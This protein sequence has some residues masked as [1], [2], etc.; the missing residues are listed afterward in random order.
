M[1][2][3]QAEFPVFLAIV[4]LVYW[5]IQERRAQNLWLLGASVVFYGWVHP[6]FVALLFAASLV[7]FGT[8]QLMARVPAYK[9]ALLALSVASNLSLLAYF[10]YADFGL[11]NVIA[12]LD[13]L[14]LAHDVRLL[15]VMLPIGISFYTFQTIGYCVDVYRGE[16]RARRDLLDYLTYVSF[17]PQ[18]VA[19]P[20]ER[21]GRLL[22]QVERARVF[23]WTAMSTGVSLIAWG[24]FKKVVIADSVA[25]FVDKVFVLRDPAAPLV[26]AATAAFMIQIF[27][28][29]SGYTDIARGVARTLGFELCENFREPFLARTTPEFWQRWHMSLSTWIRDYVLG[30][31]VGDDGA[32]PRRFAV[33][34]VV[35]FALI[36]FWHGAAWNYVLFGVFHGLWVVAY[37]QAARTWPQ[38]PRIPSAIAVPFHLLAVGLVGSFIFREQDVGRIVDHLARW[39]WV[40]TA[41]DWIATVVL[42]SVTFAFALPLVAKWALDRF[43]ATRSDDGTWPLPVVTASWAL[44]ACAIFVFHRVTATDFVYFQF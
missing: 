32:G 12:A 33:A 22:P 21:A 20:I 24:A 8:T 13:A 17:F 39:P 37:G 10:K 25:P 43:I 34:T 41:S 27:A 31:L 30:P 19:G 7:D 29:F 18:L 36:G 44:A 11:S 38:A 14:G 16:L 4:W 3:V 9:R 2:F 5:R 1:N 23:T 15:G 42:L 26:W 40:G 28:D 6:W 35:T